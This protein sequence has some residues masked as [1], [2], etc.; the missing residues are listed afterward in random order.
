MTTEFSAWYSGA[1][2]LAVGTVLVLA[3]WSFRVALAGRPL[4]RDEFLEAPTYRRAA[5]QA[6]RPN[7]SAGELPAQPCP[8]ETQ[9]VPYRVNGSREH[10][11]SFLGSHAAEIVHFDNPPQRRVFVRER[12]QRAVQIQKL[13]V[14]AA[15][16]RGH[17]DV[18]IPGN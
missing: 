3:I 14:F 8:S 6:L 11:R 18:G 7:R 12:L 17:L 2:L 15:A 5:A 10:H 4:L 13:H 16:A 9:V 1:T